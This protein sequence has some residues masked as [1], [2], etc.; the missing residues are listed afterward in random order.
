MPFDCWVQIH[1]DALKHFGWANT[2]FL[3]EEKTELTESPTGSRLYMTFNEKSSIDDWVPLADFL[4]SR[5]PENRP[6]YD[7]ILPH[8]RDEVLQAY[9]RL[10]MRKVHAL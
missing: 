8:L 4:Y 10:L 9:H 7:L 1:W 6:P 2:F 5:E 3:H